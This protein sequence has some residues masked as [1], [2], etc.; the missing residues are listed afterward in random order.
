MLD[1]ELSYK[2]HNWG[3]ANFNGSVLS[4]EIGSAD[5]FEIPLPNVQVNYSILFRMILVF[6]IKKTTTLLI[7]NVDIF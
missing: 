7:N 4:F 3:T 5:A 2:G 1:R 6:F